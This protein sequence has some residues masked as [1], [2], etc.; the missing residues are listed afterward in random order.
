MALAEPQSIFPGALIPI[1]IPILHNPFAL[2]HTFIKLSIVLRKLTARLL[3]I[4]EHSKPVEFIVS[5]LSIIT[6]FIPLQNPAIPVSQ[7]IQIV[8]L[9]PVTDF[10]PFRIDNHP[11]T[12]L[13]IIFPLALID[14]AILVMKAAQTRIVTILDCTFVFDSIVIGVWVV[15]RALTV[16][17]ILD[18]ISVIHRA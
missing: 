13:F 5:P 6:I 1:S 11:I 9:V 17:S 12:T 14:I 7:I 2:D 3:R 4:A 8:A 16:F 15:V 18:P 10:V